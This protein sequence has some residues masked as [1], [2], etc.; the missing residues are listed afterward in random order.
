VEAIE[1]CEKAI[2]LGNIFV[3]YNMAI[4]YQK[5]E[6]VQLNYQKSKRVL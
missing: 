4:M 2:K 5:G 3:M 6:S 1:L